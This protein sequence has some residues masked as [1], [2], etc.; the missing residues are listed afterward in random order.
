MLSISTLYGT[1]VR[2]LYVH[3]SNFTI[4]FVSVAIFSDYFTLIFF[5]FVLAEGVGV[6]DM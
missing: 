3:L 2:L 4:V 5:V 1:F 6:R